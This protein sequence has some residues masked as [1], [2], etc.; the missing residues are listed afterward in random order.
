[1]FL[2]LLTRLKCDRLS[3]RGSERQPQPHLMNQPQNR[4]LR[5]EDVSLRCQSSGT[6]HRPLSL[7]PFNFT[8]ADQVTEINRLFLFDN[9]I[10]ID[11]TL[12]GDETIPQARDGT[13]DNSN[14]PPFRFQFPRNGAHYTLAYRMV[15]LLPTRNVSQAPPTPVVRRPHRDA[16][17]AAANPIRHPTYDEHFSA[18]EMESHHLRMELL[19]AARVLGRLHATLQRLTRVGN[20]SPLVAV[21]APHEEVEQFIEAVEAGLIRQDHDTYISAIPTLPEYLDLEPEPEFRDTFNQAVREQTSFMRTA[22]I[23]DLLAQIA[24]ELVS[25]G[26]ARGATRAVSS[27]SGN[28]A[29]GG[30]RG[31]Y[32]RMT[33]RI[34]ALVARL[35]SSRRSNADGTDGVI[36]VRMRQDEYLAALRQVFPGQFGDNIARMVDEIG[37]RSA[38]RAVSDPRFIQAVQSGNTTLAGTLF[39]S[40]AA[41]EA[42]AV[43]ASALPQGWTLTAE[44]VIQAGAGGSRT[45][46]LFRG[47][48]GQ[49]VEIDWKTTGR[50]ALSSA[51]RREMRRHAGQITVNT[52][53]IVTRQESRSWVDY[54]RAPLQAIGISWP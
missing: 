34:R 40:A 47:P 3:H 17:T 14:D 36:V 4:P 8:A 44:E 52:G 31:I 54:V 41:A 29:R 2:V 53:G 26:V 5:G 48:A 49:R 43:P 12:N 28:L 50:S 20:V 1:M 10:A 11:L 30:V 22:A 15:Q 23:V 45:D 18:A 27:A 21:G 39:H 38:Q 51:A 33:A 35:R 32:R 42:R 7:G 9:M 13:A 19:S 24:S 46:L 16:V 37:Q 6:R 25:W